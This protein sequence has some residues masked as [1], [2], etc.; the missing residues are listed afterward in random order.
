MHCPAASWEVIPRESIWD[1]PHWRQGRRVFSDFGLAAVGPQSETRKGTI[2]APAVQG[3]AR[4]AFADVRKRH[5]YLRYVPKKAH[6]FA[7]ASSL[8]A[9]FASSVPPMAMPPAPIERAGASRLGPASRCP[10]PS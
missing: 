5:N 2:A 3:D 10:A 8:A 4:H 9:A 6:T 7:H 1:T